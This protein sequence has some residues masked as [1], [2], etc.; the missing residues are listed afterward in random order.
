LELHVL[1]KLGPVFT[2]EM[3]SA[4]SP[5]LFFSAQHLGYRPCA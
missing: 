3:G 1:W 4:F 2:P 5:S